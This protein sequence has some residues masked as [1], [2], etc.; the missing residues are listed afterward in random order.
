MQRNNLP[1]AARLGVGFGALGL[2]LVVV[3]FFAGSAIS[4][5]KGELDTMGGRDLR[6]L[7]LV[8]EIGSRAEA[9]GH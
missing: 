4:G 3:A 6:T 9:I 5:L 2:A 7:T 1:L 8:S